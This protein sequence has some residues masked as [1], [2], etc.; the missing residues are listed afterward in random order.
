MPTN[1]L[2]RIRANIF[3][4]YPSPPMRMGGCGSVFKMKWIFGLMEDKR[5]K[6]YS[7]NGLKKSPLKY[8]FHISE[9]ENR[10]PF[11]NLKMPYRIERKCNFHP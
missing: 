1:I 2:V 7:F 3:F 9:I 5:K 8:P 6:V 4:S 10:K 11:I